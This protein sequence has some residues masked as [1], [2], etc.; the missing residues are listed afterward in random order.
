M[1]GH[2]RVG[3]GGTSPVGGV[4]GGEALYPAPVELRQCVGLAWPDTVGE[5]STR[6]LDRDTT[7]K[8]PNLNSVRRRRAIG[9]GGG[10]YA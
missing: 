8:R 7:T 5:T 9:Y 10:P 2:R 4:V 3:G 1:R 6:R